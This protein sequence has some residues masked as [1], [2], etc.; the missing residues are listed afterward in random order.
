MGQDGILLGRGEVHKIGKE[1]ASYVKIPGLELG[2]KDGSYISV[3]DIA[4]S[5]ADICSPVITVGGRNV[6]YEFGQNFGEISITLKLY[7]GCV[8]EKSSSLLT[9]VTNW[10]KDNRI[11]KKKTPIQISIAEDSIAYKVYIHVMSLGQADAAFNTQ[12]ITFR[13]YIA[14]LPQ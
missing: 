11:S 10:Y 14:P 9:Q 2:A 4:S 5:D 12:I 1:G 7:M 3:Q 13:G 8:L 6:I